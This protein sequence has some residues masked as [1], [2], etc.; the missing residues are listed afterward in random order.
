MGH[1]KLGNV[2]DAASGSIGTIKRILQNWEAA[3]V[4]KLLLFGNCN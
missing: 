4:Q 3:L 2:G 1:L